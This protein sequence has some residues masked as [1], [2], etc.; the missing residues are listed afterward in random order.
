M[1]RTIFF[2]FTIVL[3]I[4]THGVLAQKQEKRTKDEVL[5]FYKTE[6]YW[7]RSI[8]TGIVLMKDLADDHDFELSK[9]NDAENFLDEDLQKYKLIVFLNTSG[10]VFNEEEQEAFKKYI[11]NGGNFF[12]IHAAADTEMDWPWFGSLVGGVFKNHP[13]IQK[14]RIKVNKPQHPTIKH[15]PKIW[16]RTDE[17]YNYKNLDPGNQVLLVLDEDSYEGGTNGAKHPIAWY[18]ETGFG[19][20]SI[21]TG[22]GHT[23]QSYLEP[24]FKEHILQCILFGLNRPE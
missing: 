7:H 19:G 2:I 16:T 6:G 8:A 13:K 4:G 1:L 20:V 14:A 9:T 18:K 5:L 11:E 12:G 3:F 15:L 24:E 10:N 21:Y 17:W 22:V 23:I